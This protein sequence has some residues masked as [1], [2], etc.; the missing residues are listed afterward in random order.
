MS[1]INV[2][3]RNELK[4]NL[5]R[6]QRELNQQSQAY[7][8]LKGSAVRNVLTTITSVLA[9]AVFWMLAMAAI[10]AR[11][12]LS[13][14]EPAVLAEFT[15]NVSM[16]LSVAVEAMASVLLAVKLLLLLLS[17]LFLLISL[18]FGRNRRKSK[19]LREAAKILEHMMH[20]T[21][22]NIDRSQDKLKGFEEFAGEFTR[23]AQ[24]RGRPP[25]G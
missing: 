24:E 12:R 3:I 2:E 14:M 25:E 11:V 17:G 19:R 10:V 4:A 21:R 15:E 22:A 16:R 23:K 20:T 18:L 1:T 8:E 7:Y 5:E 13:M 6:L 9:E